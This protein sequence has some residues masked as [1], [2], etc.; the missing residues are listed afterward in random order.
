[1]ATY[2]LISDEDARKVITALEDASR[3]SSHED[4]RAFFEAAL[5]TLHS[6]LHVTDAIPADF[7][8]TVTIHAG[9]NMKPETAN[10]L[11]EMTRLAIEMIESGKVRC[12]S[13]GSLRLLPP[14]EA[15]PSYTCDPCGRDFYLR[16]QQGE[17][18]A[19]R[20]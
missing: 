18:E 10:A 2:W 11:S 8:P 19:D 15:W 14:T 20:G 7:Q 6:G 4:K 5:H 9:P 17:Q 16:R 3:H 1:M 12:P 13:C